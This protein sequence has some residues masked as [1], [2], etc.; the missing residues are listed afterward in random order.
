MGER[1]RAL[2]DAA[3]LPH[4]PCATA[5]VHRSLN[6]TRTQMVKVWLCPACDLSLPIHIPLC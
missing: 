6:P 3:G 1:D 2:M 5:K 4:Q